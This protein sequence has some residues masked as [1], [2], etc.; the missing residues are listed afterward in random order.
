[1]CLDLATFHS[2]ALVSPRANL[3]DGDSALSTVDVSVTVSGVAHRPSVCMTTTVAFPV[4]VAAKRHLSTVSL[5]GTVG[6]GS[7]SVRCRDHY[8]SFHSQRNRK[9]AMRSKT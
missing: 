9:S 4:T 3:H 1:M 7:A 5:A 8:W 6:T 2:A